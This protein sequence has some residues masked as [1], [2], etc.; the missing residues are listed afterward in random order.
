[1]RVVDGN[2]RDVN[3]STLFLGPSN[4]DNVSIHRV[5]EPNGEIR[6]S[7]SHIRMK[8][9]CK[10]FETMY[11]Y[12]EQSKYLTYIEGLILSDGAKALS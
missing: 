1:M 4:C 2:N 6:V 11:N 8:D 7:R 9:I 12:E 5:Y 3:N 10:M